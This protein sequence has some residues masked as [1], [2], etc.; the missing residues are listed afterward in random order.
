M[1]HLFA[2]TVPGLEPFVQQELAGL[3]LVF[4]KSSEAAIESNAAGEAREDAGGVAFDASL[5]DLYRANLHLRSANRIVARLG[6]FYAA[7][8]SELRK[9]A[10]RLSWE[11][12]LRPGQ[13]VAIR[14]T[15]HKSKLY[16]S[17]A[18]AERI[19]GAIEDR[20]KKP[21]ELVKFDPDAAQ[22]PQLILVR[23]V[24]DHCTISVDTSGP[25]LNRRGYR[26]ETAKAP[27]RETLAAGLLLASGWDP[28]C[29]LIDPFCG[30]GTIPIEAALLARRIAPGKNRRF[31]FMDWPQFS[32]KV[33]RSQVAKAVALERPLPAPILASDRDAGAIRIAQANAERAG[34]LGDIQFSCRAFSAI[35][36]P[37]GNPG[38]MITNPPYGVRVSPTQDLRNLYTQLGTVLRA[39]CPDWK[40]GML[41][42]SDLL[43]GHTRLHFE[44]T[45]PLINGGIAVK[46]YMGSV[47]TNPVV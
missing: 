34:V 42:S 14:V 8:F 33:W 39:L 2:V 20:L 21:S 18:V 28:A 36:P 46:Y 45:L 1:Y 31:A 29:A 15:C 10:S 24:H 26:L 16:H 22:I 11:E 7:A 3:G 4:A 44:R 5:T 23:L 13:P 19:A 9:K 12:F 30:S 27:L 25:L 6:D 37:A 17:A 41:C 40:L 43:S 32:S 38:W 35:E 47:P